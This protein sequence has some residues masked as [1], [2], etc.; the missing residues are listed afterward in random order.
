MRGQQGALAGGGAQ[1]VGAV[2][3]ST[4]T[5]LPRETEFRPQRRS[6]TAF[7]NGVWERENGNGVEST[8]SAGDA[9]DFDFRNTFRRE[10]HYL[11][12]TGR[13]GFVI[14]VISVA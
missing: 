5:L 12:H 14:S 11:F 9:F 2:A 8:V 1:Q 7:A 13:E 3:A 4:R 6:Q 10:G